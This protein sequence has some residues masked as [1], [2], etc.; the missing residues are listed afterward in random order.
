M[1]DKGKC[2]SGFSNAGSM[3]PHQFAL[4]SAGRG[5]AEM[6]A[7]GPK[8]VFS[9]KASQVKIYFQER[10]QQQKQNFI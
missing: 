5:S 8:S 7:N 10:R 9:V 4:G 3:H 1:I 2:C 6:I